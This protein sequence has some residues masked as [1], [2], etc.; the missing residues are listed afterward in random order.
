MMGE[1]IGKGKSFKILLHDYGCYPFIVDLAQ[2]L[3]K[4]GFE[5]VF[6][7][8]SSDSRRGQVEPNENLR[9]EAISTSVKLEKSNL[10]SRYFAEK[11]FGDLIAKLIISEKPD[12]VISANAP[13]EV[14]SAIWT[15]SRKVSC[16]FVYWMQDALSV[17]ASRILP[18][19]VPVLGSLIASRYRALEKKLLCAAD[20]VIAISEPFRDLAISW[21]VSSKVITVIPNWAP[22]QRTADAAE[23]QQWREENN[24]AGKKTL[25][26]SGTLGAKHNPDALLR[27]SELLAADKELALVV[28]AE[29]QGVDWL[30][31]NVDPS[32][33][34]N[35]V[36]LPFQPSAKMPVALQSASA[37]LVLLESDASDYCVPSKVWTYMQAGRPLIA[38]MP[39]SNPAAQII[40]GHGCGFVVASSDAAAIADSF[41]KLVYEG[42][43]GEK[44]SSA[45]LN[46]A[47]QHFDI[48]VLTDSFIAAMEPG[49]E[50]ARARQLV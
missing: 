36:L 1:T 26:Y 29:G 42:G 21:G 12:L 43:V 34:T 20:A 5:V 14:Q 19:K 28:I 46:Y 16:P 13:L 7:Y 9:V 31:Q 30:R 33:H 22:P 45:A 41:K 27:L 18:R 6:A 10:V 49:G 15:A 35:L 23:I 50:G 11:E 47:Q 39:E 40:E 3:S 8:C 24:L 2:S 17:A 32:K 4:R 44:A 48:E 25:I 38:A 37:L